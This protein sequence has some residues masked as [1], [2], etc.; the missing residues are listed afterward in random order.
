M[1]ANGSLKR[2]AASSRERQRKR[3]RMN[4]GAAH[5]SWSRDVQPLREGDRAMEGLLFL[6]NIV[7][8]SGSLV[9]APPAACPQP[10]V[11]PVVHAVSRPHG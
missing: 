1:P 4:G 5:G 2:K 11:L 10:C 3:P 7:D 8:S 6:R 9:P